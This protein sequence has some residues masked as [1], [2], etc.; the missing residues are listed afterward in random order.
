LGLDAEI[1]DDVL[2]KELRRFAEILQPTPRDGLPIPSP[3]ERMSIDPESDM[4]SDDPASGI[5]S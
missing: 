5:G 1:P 4:P 2:A 3:R